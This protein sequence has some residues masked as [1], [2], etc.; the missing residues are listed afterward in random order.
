MIYLAAPW[1]DPDP[2][3]RAERARLA[4]LYAAYLAADGTPVFS[5]LTHSVPLVDA[6]EAA[7]LKMPHGWGYWSRVDERILSVCSEL[8]VLMLPGWEESL[9]VGAE[10]QC[11][12][13]WGIPIRYVEA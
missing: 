8:Y 5:P 13:K 1:T 2:A 10:V 6:G 11:A 12:R 9:G 3:V 4:T 7:G